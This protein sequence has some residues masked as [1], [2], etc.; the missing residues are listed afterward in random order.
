MVPNYLL[1][2]STWATRRLRTWS[3]WKAKGCG[4]NT[5]HS[6]T[7]G[8]H[9]IHK[10]FLPPKKRLE[11]RLREISFDDLPRTFQDAVQITR[12]LGMRYLWIDGLCI[13]QGDKH[14][15]ASE[16][17]RM[18]AVYENASL[19]IA[20]SGSAS[21]QKGCFITGTRDLCSI[22]LPY[23]TEDG[24][25]EGYVHACAHIP[26]NRWFPGEGPLQNRGWALQEA[27]F[28]RRAIHFM[29][30]GPSWSCREL[31]LD[32]RN[33]KGKPFFHK[34]W[35]NVVENYSERRL[36][37]ESDRL[38]AIQA[39]ANELQ[40]KTG[41]IYNRGIFLSRLPE[42][43]LWTNGNMSDAEDL[44]EDLV[45]LP[46]WTWASKGGLKV[47]LA[48]RIS[49]C[50]SP[51]APVVA[52]DKFRID[53]SGSLLVEDCAVL[54]HTSG[55]RAGGI[56]E[57]LDTQLCPIK[58]MVG[59]A[60]N[61]KGCVPFY[62]TEPSDSEYPRLRGVAY[63]DEDYKGT[64][65]SLPLTTAAGRNHSRT[66]YMSSNDVE[67]DT[68]SSSSS[69]CSST[70]PESQHDGPDYTSY[71]SLL[72]YVVMDRRSLSVWLAF[73]APLPSFRAGI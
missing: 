47:F 35:E 44:A 33:R 15:W 16:A 64:V 53:G 38:M 9:H 65:H 39:Y 71:M 20:A 54:C 4:E 61:Y 72:V 13:V 6:A 58:E 62:L 31:D 57:P 48:D 7:A 30:G 34:D 12:E 63:F 70:S 43:L 36:T 22:N 19:V 67:S 21:A 50:V 28:A 42:Q 26:G 32:E 60:V 46:S 24:Q 10:R 27:Y 1:V 73:P 69:T 49:E 25:S 2:L 8:A 18:G 5:A 56:N 55:G 37:Y 41:N 40:K 14:D 23:Y 45:G 66:R 59:M 51:L 17:E 3:F 29:P 11:D 68:E 52:H